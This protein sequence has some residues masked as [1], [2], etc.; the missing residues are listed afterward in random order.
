M[1][2][3][4]TATSPPEEVSELPPDEAEVNSEK[5]NNNVLGTRDGD[6][7]PPLAI[8]TTTP[9]RK[10]RQI[11]D[12]T[13]SDSGKKSLS[14]T[15]PKSP[16]SP[17]SKRLYGELKKRYLM[18]QQQINEMKKERDELNGKIS[19]FA[20]ESDTWREKFEARTSSF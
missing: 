7:T 6:K 5:D 3:G 17:E 8:N 11:V 2:D 13:L 19:K 4:K 18:Q 1:E 14:P 9:T 10:G 16:V 12:D 20:A 15:I